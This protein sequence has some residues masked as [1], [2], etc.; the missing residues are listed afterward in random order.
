MCAVIESLSVP[1]LTGNFIS[2]KEAAGRMNLLNELRL[3]EELHVRVLLRI[4]L[5]Y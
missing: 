5:K 1:P 4:V 3:P 2:N